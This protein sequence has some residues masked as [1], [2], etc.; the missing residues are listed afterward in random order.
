[1]HLKYLS[2]QKENRQ[3]RQGK[4]GMEIME[5]QTTV[6]HVLSSK[7]YNGAEN[8]VC[9]II[10]MFNQDKKYQM[11][12]CSLDGPVREALEERSI[13][14]FPIEKVSISEIK[15]V[16]NTVRPDL[17]H[18]HDMR[19]SF[20]VATACNTIPLVSHIHNNNYD[21]R[22]ISLK[23]LLYAY[24]AIK[25]KHIFW[26]SQSSIDGYRFSK[27]FKSKS[28]VLYNV[29]NIEQ[30][31]EK[32]LR[33]NNK[34]YYDVVYV[35]RLTYPKNSM[36]LI[37]VLDKAI[38]KNSSIRAAIIGEGDEAEQVKNYIMEHNLENNI[39]MLGFRNN[40]Y[41]IMR[42]SKCMIMTSLWEG[43]P[44]CALEAMALGV[45]IV[46]TPTD[47][48]CE[49]VVD[50]KT[51]FLSDDDNVLVQCINRIVLDDDLHNKMS[52]LSLQRAKELMNIDNYRSR[53]DAVYKRAVTLE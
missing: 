33:D 21:S 31:E 48:L 30:L 17:I 16:I 35:G 29:I 40:P 8:V 49:L 10:N 15:R 20:F 26:V 7:T 36:R 19:A 45:P 2:D 50:S 27:M 41:K 24:A 32:A 37:R 5:K 47:G 3:Y 46:S 23:S 18:A 22:K 6:L 13:S 42:D 14:F 1:M 52:L 43:T 11:H 53:I 38:Q 34:Y 9:Q 12:Y 44:M 25:A 39:E 51:G 4:I 28:S